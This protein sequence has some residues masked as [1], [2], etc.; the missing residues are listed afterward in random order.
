MTTFR[1][2]YE[3]TAPNV[4][5]GLQQPLATTPPPATFRPRCFSAH[6]DAPLVL[7][8]T[9]GI[10]RGGME[11]VNAFL[12]ES[13]RAAG[14]RTEA[15][16]W[17]ACDEALEEYHDSYDNIFL[18][19]E[20]EHYNHPASQSLHAFVMD[21]MVDRRPDVVVTANCSYPVHAA[22]QCGIPV[23]EYWHGDN[24]WNRMEK[25]ADV[26]A[27]VSQA[28]FDLV[29]KTRTG[30]HNY[31]II[32]N[33]V[34]AERFS[35]SDAQRGIAKYALNWPDDD[36][37]ILLWV[38]RF[39]S[40][41]HPEVAMQIAAKLKGVCRLAMVGAGSDAP[42]HASAAK[43]LDIIFG[44]YPRNDMPMVFAAADCFLS[45]SDREGFGLVLTEAMAAGVPAVVPMV[46]GLPEVGGDAPLYFTVG[47]IEEAA[48]RVRSVLQL[49]ASAAQMREAG[50]ER[51]KLFSP[52]KQAA[53]FVA[54]LEEMRGGQRH[55]EDK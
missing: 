49:P 55:G 54:L 28:A 18:S 50:L 19:G 3:R 24:V 23:L 34:D 8:V 41:K 38:G 36:L 1:R 7:F 22:A 32:H 10:Y 17:E 26:V 20:V 9:H 52:E 21:I 16:G 30:A 37:P 43:G 11:V 14:W 45:T 29:Q 6:S 51:V 33:S 42:Q 46:E 53:A 4:P 13:A 48:N 5:N 31:R 15:L 47:D 35:V 40:E 39:S 2:R 12:S 25:P 44:E 27:C